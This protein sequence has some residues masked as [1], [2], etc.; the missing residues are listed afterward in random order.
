MRVNI[1]KV[2]RTLADTFTV[3]SSGLYGYE[4]KMFLKKVN[5]YRNIDYAIYES[6]DGQ[7]SVCILPELYNNGTWFY[8][9]KG[10]K[11]NINT[12]ENKIDRWYE[13]PIFNFPGY[14]WNGQDQYEF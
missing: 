1:N 6:E 13:D 8:L 5:I 10:G 14:H 2:D 4:R 11:K 3:R 12:V 7:W 9:T